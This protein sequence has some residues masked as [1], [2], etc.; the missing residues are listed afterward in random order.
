M[1]GCHGCMKELNK[2]ACPQIIFHL[3]Q[4]G[5]V[6][7]RNIGASSS[8]CYGLD[9]SIAHVRVMSNQMQQAKNCMHDNGHHLGG[10]SSHPSQT[11]TGLL[12]IIRTFRPIP[13]SQYYQVQA[14]L[15]PRFMSC[16]TRG[17]HCMTILHFLADGCH[18]RG[19]STAQRAV[20]HSSA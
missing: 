13:R 17:H 5:K 19:D 4:D 15:Q 16:Q 10:G 9:P 18:Q 1:K 12:N 8:L 11:V 14:S 3:S 20:H 7:L 2:I 6:L